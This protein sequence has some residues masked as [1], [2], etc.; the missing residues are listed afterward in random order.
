MIECSQAH[1]LIQE[2]LEN[3]LDEVKTA[4][5][6]QHLL[7]CAACRDELSE[8]ERAFTLFETQ[9]ILQSPQQVRTNVL[10]ELSRYPEE[11]RFF[12]Q[13]ASRRVIWKT[14]LSWV[15]GAPGIGLFMILL[16]IGH[17]YFL[18]FLPIPKATSLNENVMLSF[19]AILKW[20]LLALSP[21]LSILEQIFHAI[22][23]LFN[24]SPAWGSGFSQDSSVL[25]LFGIALLVAFM[26]LFNKHL[27][28]YEKRQR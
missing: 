1:W 17:H 22:S 26:A 7:K 3:H 25:I 4:Q 28:R 2:Y 15:L 20:F 5:L 9:P 10:E 18:K 6:A 8:M 13:T 12:S 23:K 27:L 24:F 11:P 16:W 19:W 21:F 14:T